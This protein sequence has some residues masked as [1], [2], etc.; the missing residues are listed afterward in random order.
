MWSGTAIS[1]FFLVFRIFVKLRSFHKLYVDDYLVLFAWFGLLASS[2]IG[3]IQ[4]ATLYE[5]YAILSG[6][7]SITPGFYERA[8]AMLR[9]VAP[10]HILFY[11]CLWAVKLSFLF[12]FRRLGFNVRGQKGWWWFVLIITILAWVAC[13]A[14]F[15][16]GCSLGSVEHIYSKSCEP[17]IEP[18]AYIIEAYCSSLAAIQRSNRTLYGNCAAD[19]VTDCLGKSTFQEDKVCDI[20]TLGQ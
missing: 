1:L 8:A 19:V 17:T 6:Q 10:L 13:I 15:P 9:C 16:Y 14:D 18:Q 4:S 5:Q 3:Q 2:I 12:F 20:L 11:S 7:M